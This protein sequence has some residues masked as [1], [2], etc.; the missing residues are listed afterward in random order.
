MESI[1]AADSP[2]LA[3]RS[4]SEFLDAILEES[5]LLACLTDLRLVLVAERRRHKLTQ[6]AE[7]RDERAAKWAS[8]YRSLPLDLWLSDPE[9]SHS[10]VNGECR[11]DSEH[12]DI[13]TVSTTD[14][15]LPMT[16]L[17][18]DTTS[19]MLDTIMAA[20]ATDAAR[21][22][23]NS[24]EPS[25]KTAARPSLEGALNHP[26]GMNGA[27]ARFRGL[28]TRLRDAGQRCCENAVILERSLQRRHSR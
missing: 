13:K 12:M 5:G 17:M 16:S 15:E 24:P 27:G 23:E 22:A 28:R 1:V 10:T 25:L 4:V 11:T 9:G 6:E 18:F 2:I 3:Y 8:S 19:L 26:Q 21:V 14:K 20:P 7:N